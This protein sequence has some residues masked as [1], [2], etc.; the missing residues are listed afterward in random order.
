MKAVTAKKPV[1]RRT[2][3]NVFEDIGFPKPEAERLR[4]MAEL[5]IQIERYIGWRCLVI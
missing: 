5:A 4:I 1:V 3:G 2:S